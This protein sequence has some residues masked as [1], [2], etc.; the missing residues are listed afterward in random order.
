M[1]SWAIQGFRERSASSSEL[2]PPVFGIIWF[3]K[4]LTPLSCLT[5]LLSVWCYVCVFSFHKDIELDLS[6]YFTMVS[7]LTLSFICKTFSWWHH[8]LQCQVDMNLVRVRKGKSSSSTC[9]PSA[10]AEF[11]CCA[12]SVKNLA[13]NTEG[14]ALGA[15]L[16][17]SLPSRQRS[18]PPT[19]LK[20]C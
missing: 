3:R 18:T 17:H 7:S 15:R 14:E 6:P 12:A 1:G 4:H 13:R 20:A 9:L 19:I 2:L 10:M 16:P 5:S 8:I 11:L